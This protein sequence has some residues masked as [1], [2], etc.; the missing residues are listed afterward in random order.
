MN[1]DPSFRFT[2]Y[3]NLNIIRDSIPI[4]DSSFCKSLVFGSKCEQQVDFQLFTT[5]TMTSKFTS[6]LRI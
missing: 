6:S 3:M 4:P 2:F 5:D 1:N